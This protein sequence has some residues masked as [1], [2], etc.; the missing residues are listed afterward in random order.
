MDLAIRHCQI[1]DGTGA[2]PREGDIGVQHGRVE[3]VGVVGTAK[4]EIDANGLIVCPGFVDVHAHDD[5]AVLRQ[6]QLATKLA[7]GCTTVVVGNCGFSLFPKGLNRS[8]GVLFGGADISDCES[9]FRAVSSVRPSVNVVTL[10][11][12]NTVRY[13]VMGNSAAAPSARELEE[14]RQHVRL[15]VTT[16]V[17][18]LSTG[19]IYEPGRHADTNELVALASVAAE[20]RA[21]YTTH[22]RSE[23]DKLVEAVGEA[24]NI[25]KIAGIAVHISHHKASGSQNWGKVRITLPLMTEAWTANNCV[26]ADVYPYTSASGPM[27]QYFDLS[28]IDVAY[29]HRVSIAYCPDFPQ[30]EGRSLQEIAETERRPIAE[31]AYSVLSS[32]RAAEVISIQSIMCEQDVQ[33]VLSHKLV[34]VGTDGLPTPGGIPHPRLY[35]TFPR[36]LGKYVRDRK[37]LALPEAVH[38]MT[39]LP[40]RTFGI[41]DRGL[42]A[43]GYWADLVMFDMA[44]I[45]DPGFGECFPRGIH[46]VFVNGVLALTGKK[47]AEPGTG[48]VIRNFNR[49][50]I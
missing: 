15:A 4:Q 11:G 38:K 26:S 29:A 16:G 25:G 47:I 42:I 21:I 23:G 14:M 7:Q 48:V 50:S 9:Y 1:I 19:L 20:N 2:P 45:S 49:S 28:R 46:S 18:G 30:Y 34:M 36:I 27:H 24:L 35:G 41:L 33:Y 13:A 43:E 5:D 37:L 44:A 40:A 6:P 31:V 32:A 39:A 3:A 17:V 8:S 12:H 22:L 10:V